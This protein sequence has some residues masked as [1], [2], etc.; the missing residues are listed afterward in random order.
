MPTTC[1]TVDRSPNEQSD[2][3]TEHIGPYFHD[4]FSEYM[5][6]SLT[7]SFDSDRLQDI[8]PGWNHGQQPIIS[9]QNIH[10]KVFSL[11]VSTSYD[12]AFYLQV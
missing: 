6:Y 3:C 12:L 4:L 7:S 11:V 1:V 9:L 10:N 5:S 2:D 8:L